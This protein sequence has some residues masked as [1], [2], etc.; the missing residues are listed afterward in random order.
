MA[1]DP[2]T[3]NVVIVDPRGFPTPEFLR[4]WENQKNVNITVNSVS[5][6]LTALLAEQLIA[7][8]GL[9]GGGILGNL[10]NITFNLANTAVTPGAYTNANITVDAQGR[11]TAAANGTSGGGTPTVVQHKEFTG[12][13]ITGGTLDAAPTAGNILIAFVSGGSITP[14]TGW[15]L[16]RTQDAGGSTFANW[17]IKIAGVGE[18]TTQTPI[19]G[20]GIN[21]C[22]S[23][24]E[25][26]GKPGLA[27]IFTN[28]TSTATS[29]TITVPGANMLVIGAAL[30][31][32]SA[33]NPT[34][35]TNATL[36]S[37]ASASGTRG[38]AAFSVSPA[39]GA[40]TI[41]ANYAASQA[42]RVS[43]IVVA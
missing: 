33:V 4:Q 9:T 18:S 32:T 21:A 36:L 22:I 25:I 39:A 5:V 8:T 13:P 31:D 2:L 12:N 38:A 23:I 3:R 17:F 35:I 42:N 6:S 43:A 34:S 37:G 40:L 30:N 19:S 20:A 11:I 41:T 15:S 27:L 14:A 7:G 24:F 28:T 10:V 26:T 29:V 1:V 16:M